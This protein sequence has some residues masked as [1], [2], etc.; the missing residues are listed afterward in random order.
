MVVENGRVAAIGQ[1]LS[2]DETVDCRGLW[3]LPGAIDAHVHS[4]D[5]GFPAKETWAS[6]T[7]A[8]AVGGVTTVID[9]PNTVPAVDSDVV[10][11][12]KAAIAS[13]Q[14]LVDFGLWG[15][16][17]SGSTPEMLEGLLKA[18]AAGLKAYLGYSYRR[19][20]RA[21]TYTAMLDDPDLEAPP[22]YE[23][24]A[25]LA[26][27]GAL[28]AV[29]GEDPDVLRA[30]A[31]P[32]L[33]YADVL[34]ARPAEAEAIA[35]GRAAALGL[36][37]HAVH[38]SSADGL[39]AARRG[40]DVSVETCP[41]YLW[42]TA[43]DYARV[44]NALRMNPPVRAAADREALRSGVV[45]GRVDTIGT[46]HAPHTDAEK[47]D[48]DLEHCHPGS[49]GVQTLLLST[50]QLG[51]DLGAVERVI[52]CVTINVA[53]RLRLPGKGVISPGA[54]ADLVL[55]DPASETVLTAQSMRSKQHHGV[56]EGMRVGFAIRAVYSRGDLLVRDG[57]VVA[58]PGRG[59][60]VRPSRPTA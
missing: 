17:R 52:A 3:V 58:A 1:G 25:R 10:F 19:T 41:Q 30:R 54:D 7:E 50:L 48:V 40:A 16:L 20:A 4:R 9:M 36:R 56:L 51:H 12:Q 46:D 45:S 29:H 60:L 5:P 35:L 18:G 49:P 34:L 39:E 47:F 33:T 38:V 24:I 43:D 6:L 44:G 55:I 8:A 27:A 11:H 28:V 42:A 23:D 31:R 37:L 53:E 59:R 32:L 15:L 2:A 22:G 13:S 26:P 14:A 21:V 57:E